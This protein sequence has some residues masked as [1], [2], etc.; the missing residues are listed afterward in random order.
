MDQDGPRRTELLTA[1]LAQHPAVAQAQM[2]KIE[3]APGQ[4]VGAHHHPCDVVGIVLHGHI[5]FEIDGHQAVVL[6]AGDAFFE[7][8]DAHVLHFDNENANEPAVFVACYLL[9]PGQSEV[10]RMSPP[11]A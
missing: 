6:S 8:R 2:T 7:P 9:G 4:A 5:R 10:I 3:L 1:V 11:S